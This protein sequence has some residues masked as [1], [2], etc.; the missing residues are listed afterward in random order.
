MPNNRKIKD[1]T[2]LYAMALIGL[3]ASVVR[4]VDRLINSTNAELGSY[5]RNI[6]PKLSDIRSRS[7]NAAFSTVRDTVTQIRRAGFVK[8]KAFMIAEAKKFLSVDQGVH[9]KILDAGTGVGEA[10]LSKIV[11]YG[12]FDGRT[13]GD[14]WTQLATA[15]IN[16]IMSI[17]RGGVASGSSTE[18]LV[19]QIKASVGLTNR[20][21]EMLVR[22]V[23]NG[24]A[25]EGKLLYYEKNSDLVEEVEWS[26]ILDFRTSQIC[27]T[28]HGERWPINSEHPVP[29]AHPNCRSII[30]PVLASGNLEQEDAETWLRRQPDEVQKSILGVKK[31]QLFRAGQLP[32]SRL[33]DPATVK[34][35]TLDELAKQYGV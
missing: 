27:L 29:P 20:G 18:D 4:E 10:E 8:A 13:L 28:L 34:P 9:E 5:V 16:R 30:I 33:I 23:M 19:A 22:T 14:W 31:A 24:I 15:D 2:V 32:I 21:A 12:A 11:T 17:I 25:N 35:I 1:E 7:S 26:A 6:I 3:S